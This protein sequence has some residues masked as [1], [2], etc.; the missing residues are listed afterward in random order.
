M[1]ICFV[2]RI[3]TAVLAW[4]LLSVSLLLTLVPVSQAQDAIPTLPIVLNLQVYGENGG[5]DIYTWHEG[6]TAVTRLSTWG[7]NDELA[8]SPDGRLVAYH[9]YARVTVDAINRTGGFGGG[10][11]PGN[12]W[13]MDT[14]TGDGYRVADQPPD[15][16][17]LTDNDKAIIRSQP[18][19]SPDGMYLAWVEHDYPLDDHGRLRLMIYDLATGATENPVDDLSPEPGQG[20]IPQGTWTESGIVVTNLGLKPDTEQF[21]FS[22]GYLVYAPDGTLL[23]AFTLETS[24]DHRPQRQ[25]FSQHHDRDVLVTLYNDGIWEMTDVLTGEAS[26][27]EAPSAYSVFTPGE[28]MH[29][30]YDQEGAL[31]IYDADGE[32]LDLPSPRWN[33]AAIAPDG[34]AV[35]YDLMIY[36]EDSSTQLP[37]PD[38]LANVIQ[39]LWAP[40][41]WILTE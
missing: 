39:T 12:I 2:K 27:V 33:E 14:V 28:G 34:Q 20:A 16:A 26:P 15:A 31:M 13:V 24:P 36:R 7:W 37:A 4:V 25:V 8:L 23:N 40:L 6:D 11:G 5:E 22:F 29:L 3:A 18:F 32:L 10:K 17:F 9:S 41:V 19:W 21:E 38:D 35:S 1:N 30:S